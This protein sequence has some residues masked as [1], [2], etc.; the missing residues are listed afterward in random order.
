MGFLINP[1]FSA[2][3]AVT[4]ATYTPFRWYD[5]A[6]YAL[7][8]NALVTAADPWVDQSVNLSNATTVAG[9]EPTFKTS[10][11]GSLPAVRFVGAKFMNLD[12]G[13]HS[14]GDLTF[15]CIAKISGDT[16]W[17][18]QNGINVQVRAFRSGANTYS[19]YPN[20]GAEIVSPVLSIAATDAKMNVWRRD[21]GPGT[22]DFYEDAILVTGGVN[23]TSIPIDQIGHHGG[24][25]NIDIG[26]IVLY[27]TVLADADVV[28]LYNSYFKPK[29]GLP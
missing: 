10:I 29:F 11:F 5:A 23:D 7:A 6:T 27:D 26:E 22:V 1:F 28:A 24:A 21:Q 16:V 25:T 20:F 15:F 9:K 18:S 13:V 3:A 19:F 17:L 2:A 12:S 8:D 4:P 14:F